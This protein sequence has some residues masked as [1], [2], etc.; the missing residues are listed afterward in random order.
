MMFAGK[1]AKPETWLILDFIVTETSQLD[2]EM[3]GKKSKLFKARE[4]NGQ[5]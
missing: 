5:Y 4:Q 1:K 3:A 2:R